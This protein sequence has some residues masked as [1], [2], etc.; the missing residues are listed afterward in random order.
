ML[1]VIH[2]V[3][4]DFMHPYNWGDV[5]IKVAVYVETVGYALISL[6]CS[7][8]ERP[9]T[10]LVTVAAM[11][12]AKRYHYMPHWYSTDNW[13]RLME[14]VDKLLLIFSELIESFSN[15]FEKETNT[16]NWEGP[17]EI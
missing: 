14:K 9:I 1:Q 5:H 11:V 17:E 2:Y 13:T 4:N 15:L 16:A 10:L 6:A 3:D 8:L 12:W 7:N